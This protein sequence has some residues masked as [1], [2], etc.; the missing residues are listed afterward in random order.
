[1]LRNVKELIELLNLPVQSWRFNPHVVWMVGEFL[2]VGS[3]IDDD[4]QDTAGMESTRGNI[5][6]QF[7]DR[8]AKTSNAKVTQS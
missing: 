8:N 3:H 1:M 7:T 6:I 2:V 4:R 5:Q